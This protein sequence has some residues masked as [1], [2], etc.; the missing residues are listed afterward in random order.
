MFFEYNGGS[1]KSQH[2]SDRHS[3]IVTESGVT[4]NGTNAHHQLAPFLC[5]LT[6]FMSVPLRNKLCTGLYFQSKC[7]G[8]VLFVLLFFISAVTAAFFLLFTHVALLCGTASVH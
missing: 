3:I 5:L 4:T 6:T 2:L 8:N 7:P 1:E